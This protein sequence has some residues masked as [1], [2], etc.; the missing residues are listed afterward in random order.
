M[1]FLRLQNR[2]GSGAGRIGAGA[3]IADVGD[4][5]FLV[6]DGVEDHVQVLGPRLLRQVVRRIAVMA[7]VVHVHV[8]VGAD[9][10]AEDCGQTLRL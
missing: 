5:L 1:V 9:P 8:Q 2:S 6:D 3:E 7:A 4:A 10:V